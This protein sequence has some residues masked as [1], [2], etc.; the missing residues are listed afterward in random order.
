MRLIG[1]HRCPPTRWVPVDCCPSAPSAWTGRPG[2][3]GSAPGLERIL[4][5]LGRSR[6]AGRRDGHADPYRAGAPRGRLAAPARCADRRQRH[7]HPDP[8]LPR[9]A[10]HV[11]V[12][13]ARGSWASLADRARFDDR[14][15]VL[16]LKAEGRAFCAGH[17]PRHARGPGDGPIAGG[18][19]AQLLRGHPLGARALPGLP[20]AAAADRRAVHGYCLGFGFELAL[21]CDIRV[22]ADDAVFALPRRRSV[23]P[24]TRAATSAWPTRS[25]PGTP[26][27]SPSPA[28]A[29]TPTTAERLG[30]VQQVTTPRRARPDRHGASPPTSP[31]NAPARR[32][33]DQAHHRRVRLPRPDR[34][35]QVRGAERV[36]RVRVRRHAG[37]RTPRRRRSGRPSSRGSSRSA[38]PPDPAAGGPQVP[39]GSSSWS[40]NWVR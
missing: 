34:G 14:I 23:S 9:E 30:I 35:A 28:G 3:P 15:R 36:G 12:G 40:A 8:R 29:S 32:A 24:S 4:V 10:Q 6:R 7:R 20:R 18:E 37:R 1:A 39:A 38:A 2:C 31:A 33:V 22:A 27:C 13:G 11:V 5:F 19:G 16:V 17:R 21:M 26:S 25:A